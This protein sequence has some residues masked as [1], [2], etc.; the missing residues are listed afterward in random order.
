MKIIRTHEMNP[1]SLSE[2]ERDMVYNGLD[3]CVTLDVYNGLR[4]QLGEGVGGKIS[5]STSA[6][7][8]SGKDKSP[9]KSSRPKTFP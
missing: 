1:D 4:P 2:F 3:C 7:N 6:T 8:A 5:A 9:E